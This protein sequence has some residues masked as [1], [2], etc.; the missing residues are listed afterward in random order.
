MQLKE[1]NLG[2]DYLET[3]A[4]LCTLCEQLKNE[5]VVLLGV[6]QQHPWQSLLV[7]HNTLN[8][9][10]NKIKAQWCK[11]ATKRHDRVL[12]PHEYDMLRMNDGPCRDEYRQRIS[13]GM[14][15]ER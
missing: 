10:A 15:G 1:S 7:A 12:T 8:D 14:R 3:L 4:E 11:P 2:K 13:A 9:I 6:Y 5:E